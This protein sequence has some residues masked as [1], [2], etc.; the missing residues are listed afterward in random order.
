M[1][2]L[3]DLLDYLV[4]LRVSSFPFDGWVESIHQAVDLQP[5]GGVDLLHTLLAKSRNKYALG[6]S[7]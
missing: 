1:P 4:L 2:Q 6:S 7:L 5:R 3:S